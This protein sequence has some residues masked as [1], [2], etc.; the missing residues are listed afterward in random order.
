MVEIH[1]DDIRFL[2]YNR[3]QNRP[4]QA[5]KPQETVEVSHTDEEENKM[6][7]N[8]TVACSDVES[9][10]EDYEHYLKDEEGTP[11]DMSDI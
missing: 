3:P 11:L 8:E 6:V 5:E 7:S 10:D 9:E 4:E 1:A 2:D